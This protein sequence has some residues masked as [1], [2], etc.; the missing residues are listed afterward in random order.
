M[1][2]SSF[3]AI[4]ATGIQLLQVCNAYLPLTRPELALI[5]SGGPRKQANTKEGQQQNLLD[6]KN[7]NGYLEPILKVRIP[8]TQG[9]EDVR[10]HFEKFFRGLDS[11]WDVELDTF[12][13][14]TPT[15]KNVNFT[16]FVAT[17]DP[18]G[19]DPGSVGRLTLVAHYDSKIEPK[20]FLGA[21]DSAFPCALIM[22]IVNQLDEALTAKWNDTTTASSSIAAADLGLQILF[23]DGE[24][25]YQEWTDTDSI[26]GARHLAHSWDKPAYAA[27]S[28]RK[29]RLDSIDL[30]VLLDL[31]GAANPSIPSYYKHTNWAHRNLGRLQRAFRRTKATR[32]KKKTSVEG[33]EEEVVV[34]ESTW[35]PQPGR[36]FLAGQIGDDHLPFFK[37]GVPVLHLIPIPF[38]NTWH[39]IIDD[40]DHLDMDAVHDWSIIMTA[41]TAEYMELSGYLGLPAKTTVKQAKKAQKAKKAKRAY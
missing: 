17:R 7:K 13:D 16:N 22:Y 30:F 9:S 23:L 34:E 1:R 12:F 21:I 24:E 35:F 10:T 14:D 2:G 32:E 20:G 11:G 8:G 25:A 26:Y 36:Y 41:F 31:L 28:I 29:S 4:A 15:L 39:K 38:P 27:T 40:G 3:L 19:S 18:P 33:K 6:P 5:G 37:R